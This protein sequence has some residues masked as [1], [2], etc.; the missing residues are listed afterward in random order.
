MVVGTKVPVR[1][2]RC[3]ANET[4]PDKGC[5]FLSSKKENRALKATIKWKE[6]TILIDFG[7]NSIQTLMKK[8]EWVFSVIE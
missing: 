2:G 4:Q 6:G 7:M 8:D 3:Q 1:V 5:V